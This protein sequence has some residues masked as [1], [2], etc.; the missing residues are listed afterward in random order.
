MMAGDRYRADISNMDNKIMDRLAASESAILGAL[1]AVNKR[2]D[3]QDTVIKNLVQEA[4]TG[5]PR[6]EC[7][8]D[9]K[10]PF[11]ETVD[12]R[13]DSLQEALV[14]HGAKLDK[15]VERMSGSN[16]ETWTEVVRKAKKPKPPTA[17]VKSRE[18][19]PATRRPRV[20]P[21]AVVVKRG[22]VIF[23]DTVK[24]I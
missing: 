11:R 20:L 2:I 5:T 16:A 10:P 6:A 17:Q 1:D 7:L 9:D 18:A 8:N 14:G 22:E 3:T 4:Q 23:A 19:A 24:N 21:K 13:L 15:M 12:C